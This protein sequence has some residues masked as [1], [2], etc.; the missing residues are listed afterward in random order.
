MKLSSYF[1]DFHIH[2]GRDHQARPVKITGAKSLTLTNVLVEASEHKGLD[3]IGVID[4][5]VPA[6][7]D[8]INHLIQEGA[9]K[10]LIDGGIQFGKT[11][12]L[13]GT[14]IEVYDENCKGPIH[15]LCYFPFL[16]NMAMFTEWLTTKMSNIHLSSQRYYGSAVELQYKVKELEGL[17]IPAH[18]FT[19]FKS[20]YG[21]GVKHS[22]KEVLDPS[23]IDA[24]ELG[25]SS[26]TMMVNGIEELKG[27]TF[28]TNS[29][30]HSLRK[31]GR[32]YQEIK[33]KIPSF[34]EFYLALYKVDERGIVRNFGMNPLL[35]KYYFTVCKK[36]LHPA[37]KGE[38]CPNC[39]SK[40]RING[41]K[42]RIEE[43][44]SSNEPPV[45]PPYIHQ[46]PLDFI[47]GLG[48]K[49]L[50]KLLTAFETEM[51]II[52][53]VPMEDLTSVVPEK[54]AKMILANRSG[55]LSITAGGGG[56]YGKIR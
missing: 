17:F 25:L 2:I 29:D 3:M 30:A 33:M 21:K 11:T 32:E 55:Q 53:H 13:L 41:V 23:L 18:I 49:T 12:L 14:E 56:K 19:P 47:P 26:D 15:V 6:V 46:V 45:R 28:L 36:C 44:V 9:A 37:K 8:E 43:L 52:H 38:I 31:I 42:E 40:A 20:L 34:K 7:Q 48:P 50:E 4:C 22:L 35:G 24:V 51:N 5:H 39:G 1:A 54:L 16:K 10:E 27:Y